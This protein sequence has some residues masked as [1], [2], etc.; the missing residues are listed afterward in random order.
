[1]S[2]KIH[3]LSE[4][5]TIYYIEEPVPG[6][7]QL[8]PKHGKRVRR[9]AVLQGFTLRWRGTLSGLHGCALKI[10]CGFDIG[11]VDFDCLYG[12]AELLVLQLELGL[13]RLV[14]MPV[15]DVHHKRAIVVAGRGIEVRNVVETAAAVLRAI[16]K[17][18]QRLPLGV[19]CK[20][21]K[22]IINGLQETG[23]FHW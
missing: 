7:R 13:N 19:V 22:R 18:L 20:E 14:L 4:F 21:L 12:T 3:P 17:Q 1:M 15:H 8:R 5:A 16:D 6:L 10:V 9:K 2:S 11:A 23:R